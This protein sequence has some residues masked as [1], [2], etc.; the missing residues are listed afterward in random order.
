MSRIFC[1]ISVQPMG[2]REECAPAVL[3]DR[4]LSPNAVVF[5]L[6]VIC[7]KSLDNPLPK[8]EEVLLRISFRLVCMRS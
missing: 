2:D 1:P 3:L 7:S 6:S 4:Q 8:D 5:V